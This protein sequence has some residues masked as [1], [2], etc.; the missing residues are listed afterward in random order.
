MQV[1]PQGDTVP[2]GSD[3]SHRLP[4]T[5]HVD[6]QA[7]ALSTP[8][9][10]RRVPKSSVL[11]PGFQVTGPGLREAQAHTQGRTARGER[12]QHGAGICRCQDL[13]SGPSSALRGLGLGS[14]W[15]KLPWR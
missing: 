1:P 9:F 2:G 8:E 7:S 11:S 15:T 12:H 6:V 3:K 14:T 5:C 4:D 13:P 10:L